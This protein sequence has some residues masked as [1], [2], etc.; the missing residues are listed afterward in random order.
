MEITYREFWT[1]VHGMG[2]GAVFL[3]AYAGGLAEL[4][5]LRGVEET[6]AGLA[7]RTR[8]LLIGTWLMAAA[9]WGV[10]LTGTW[11]VYPWYREEGGIRDALLASPNT[12][13]WHTFGMEWKEHVAWIAPFLA[14]AVAVTI[15]HY[16]RHPKKLEALRK[17]LIATFTAAFLIAGVAGLF[18]AMITKAGPIR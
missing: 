5:A 6:A 8:R 16:R 14:T 9:A 15:W 11:I 10:V 17:P 12:E 1:L 13:L 7:S 18:G 2:L 3:L 4:W